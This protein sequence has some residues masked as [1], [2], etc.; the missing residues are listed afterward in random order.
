MAIVEYCVVLACCCF[1][2]YWRVIILTALQTSTVVY[3]LRLFLVERG[4][5]RNEHGVVVEWISACVCLVSECS[6]SWHVLYLFVLFSFGLLSTCVTAGWIFEINLCEN[7][8]N[9]NKKATVPCLAPPPWTIFRRCF[10]V[11]T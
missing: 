1:L 11:V 9:K 2:H 3:F 7:S 8:I 10:L 4:T 6:S 5:G